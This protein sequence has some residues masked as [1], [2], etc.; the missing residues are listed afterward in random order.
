M[1]IFGLIDQHLSFRGFV[2]SFDSSRL[3]S[4]DLIQ[5]SCRGMGRS[6]FC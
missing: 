3:L 6:D 1:T 5:R 4:Q 2:C